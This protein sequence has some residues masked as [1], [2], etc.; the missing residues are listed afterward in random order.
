MIPEDFPTH[1]Q[2][3][4]SILTFSRVHYS[5]STF[6]SELGNCRRHILEVGLSQALIFGGVKKEHDDAHDHDGGESKEKA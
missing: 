1:T 4:R 3:E 5:Y 6:I 2:E